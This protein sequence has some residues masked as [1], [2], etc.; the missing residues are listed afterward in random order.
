MFAF[1][2]HFHRVLRGICDLQN[3]LKSDAF[4]SVLAAAWK[5]RKNA[6]KRFFGEHFLFEPSCSVWFRADGVKNPGVLITNRYVTRVQQRF[7]RYL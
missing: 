7:S 2:L 6:V 3:K 4:Y 5:H 1:F